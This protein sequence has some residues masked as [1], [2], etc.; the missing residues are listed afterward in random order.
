LRIT[1]I[2]SPIRKRAV[3]A[4]DN[5][6][7][8]P[9]RPPDIGLREAPAVLLCCRP[10]RSDAVALAM[11]HVEGRDGRW[12]IA[13]WGTAAGAG[14]VSRAVYGSHTSSASRSGVVIA[15]SGGRPRGG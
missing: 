7:R 11:G 8:A 2:T 13:E 10:R 6:R 14:G 4:T 1:R 12:C 5:G 9:E 3:A 15:S